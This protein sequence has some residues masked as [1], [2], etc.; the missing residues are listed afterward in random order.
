MLVSSKGRYAIRILVDLAENAD[1]GLVSLRDISRRQDISLKYMESIAS[2]LVSA[3][4]I[5]GFRGK[6]GGYRLAR[7]PES[8]TALEVLDATEGTVAPVTCLEEC[9]SECGRREECRSLPMWNEL[10]ELI[11][12]YFGTKTIGDLMRK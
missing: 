9:S 1:G 2:Q 7:S 10:K 5:V 12:E 4:F 8:I 6:T 11:E 3:G